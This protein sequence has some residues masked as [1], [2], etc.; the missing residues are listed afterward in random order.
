MASTI[1]ADVTNGL[2]L[3][4]DTSGEI[5]LQAGGADIAT[6]GS[7]GITM[8]SGKTIAG[9]TT[10]KILQVVSVYDRQQSSYT[11]LNINNAYTNYGLNEAGFDLTTLDA[12]ITPS[13]ASSK[14]LILTNISIG[15]DDQS[16]GVMRMK[17]GIGGATPSFSS[18]DNWISANN[19][20]AGNLSQAGSYN[21]TSRATAWNVSPI[22]FQWLDSPNTTSAVVYRFNVRLETDTGTTVYLNR[23]FYNTN[24]YGATS[25]V[26]SVTLM[27][28]A[29]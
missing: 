5:K 6:V 4:P 10:G 25:Y 27:E 18:S 15:S 2:V 9:I 28:V 24:D 13:S 26:S 14:I 22:H 3:T 17:R 16:Y 1:N 23:S 11:G 20:V 21:A 29:G 8:A 7:S 12:T 19:A